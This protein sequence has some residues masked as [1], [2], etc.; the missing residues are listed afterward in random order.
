MSLR[1]ITAEIIAKK[2]I[3][4]EELFILDVRNENDFNDWKIEGENVTAINKPYFE[5]LDGIDSIE[6]LLPKEGTIVVV[7]AKEG[8][9]KLIGNKLVE[10]GFE[11]VMYLEDGM[12][13]WSDHLEPI[14]IGKL[15]NGG[16][17]YQF[18]RIGKGCLSYVIESGD[19]AIIVDPVRTTEQ[20]INFTKE[21]G[22]TIKHVIDT[23][24]HAD[25]I[26]GARAIREQ[27]GATYWLPSKDADEV[28]FDYEKLSED[29]LIALENSDLS[30]EVV[31]SPGHTIGSMS[32]IFD[33]KYFLTGDTLFVESIGRPDLAGKAGVW[34]NDLRETLYSRY[35]DMSEELIVLPGH[36]GKVSEINNNRNVSAKLGSLF[37]VNDGLQIKDANDFY[38]KVS[39]NLPP[40]PN[41][42]KDIRQ[43]NM[44]KINPNQDE[45]QEMEIGPN[46]CAVSQ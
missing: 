34:A 27:T 7:C 31:Y 41:S 16:A 33:E 17:I 9:S 37:K 19:E 23:H 38:E 1:K 26:S 45:Q 30:I 3:N 28:V 20:F 32:I 6:D 13:T 46:R 36:F 40:Q 43:T 21:K 35:Q 12:K 8:S 11:E 4:K 24:L 42:F 44:G 22:L 29:S 39:K 15:S 2:V 10:H 14:K 5:L 18:V 25:H